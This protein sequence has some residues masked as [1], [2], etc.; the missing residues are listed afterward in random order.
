MK[1]M[2]IEIWGF[3]PY[4]LASGEERRKCWKEN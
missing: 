1:K 3:H 4:N 2:V